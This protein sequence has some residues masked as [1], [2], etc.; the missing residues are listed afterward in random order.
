MEDQVDGTELTWKAEGD[1]VPGFPITLYGPRFFSESFLDGH[2]VQKNFA[3]TY[4]WSL[5]FS[6]GASALCLST[7]F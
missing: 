1:G 2:L 5:I 6:L 4:A 3:L 7:F